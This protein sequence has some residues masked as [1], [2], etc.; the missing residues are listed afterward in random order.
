MSI[1]GKRKAA[2]PKRSTEVLERPEY[3]W[4]WK[5]LLVLIVLYLIVTIALG[6][7]WSRPPATFDVEQTVVNQ[8]SQASDV[9]AQESTSPRSRGVVIVASLMTAVETLLEKPGGYLRNDVMPPG[10]WLDN[11]PNWE[12]GVLRQARDLAQTLP[13]LSSAQQ[14]AFEEAYTRLSASSDNWLY[15]S[16]EHR[17]EQALD[18]LDSYLKEASASGETE[19]SANGDGIVRWLERVEQR[20]NSL[21]HRLSASVEEREALRD[22]V[23]VDDDELPA[24]VPWYK[25]DDTFFEARGAGWALIHLLEAMER[26]FSDVI[27][28]AGVNDGWQRL[29]AELKLTQRQIWSPVIL[30]GSGFGIFANHPLMM[31]NYMARARDLAADLATRLEGVKV[32]RDEG[33]PAQ[34]QQSPLEQKAPSPQDAPSQQEM[35]TE[36]EASAQQEGTSE[37]EASAQQERTPEQE[38]PVEGEAASESDA[39]GETTTGGAPSE[40]QKSTEEE[41]APAQTSPAAESENSSGAEH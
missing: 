33:A 10:L 18:V 24:H 5:P 25:V 2:N 16:T 35:P 15:P 21:T 20:L 1:F 17:L 23:D 13:E 29:I 30:N 34:M 26:D 3:G 28:A 14:G 31:A 39:S 27:G 9:A 7:W 38:A 11:M 12:L 19:F 22:L 37:Q 4:I 41:K 8:R 32:E 6:I 36:E 40:Q